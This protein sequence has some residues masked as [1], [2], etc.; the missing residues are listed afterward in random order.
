MPVTARL[1]RP[2]GSPL[3]VRAVIF[4]AALATAPAA[5]PQ[6]EDRP[7]TESRGD[8]FR[9]LD[10]DSDR[11][12]SRSELARHPGLAR[13]FEAMDRDRNGTLSKL[14]FAAAVAG[15]G[16]RPGRRDSLP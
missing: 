11:V 2:R 13:H 5:L 15:P 1:F 4:L 9:H 16:E 6:G 3:N 7:A 12:L 10:T 14:E 8:R